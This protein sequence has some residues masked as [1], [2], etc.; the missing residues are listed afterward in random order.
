MVA[1]GNQKA[2]IIDL[3]IPRF[4]SFSHDQAVSALEGLWTVLCVS[5]TVFP[6]VNLGIVSSLKAHMY[7]YLYVSCSNAFLRI[8]HL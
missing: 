1:A 3:W 2:Q 6:P 5:L 4:L 7:V 8:A